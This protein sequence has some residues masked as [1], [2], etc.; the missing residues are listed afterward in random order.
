VCTSRTIHTVKLARSPA[1]VAAALRG[2]PVK[3]VAGELAVNP[4]TVLKAYRELDHRGVTAGRV[5]QGT[6]VQQAVRPLPAA[7]HASLQHG[8]QNWLRT[9]F[10]AGLA[11]EDIHALV[12]EAARAIRAEGG[13]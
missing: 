11:D 10:A 1:V 2:A 6:F 13:A 4:N 5:G 9:A 7:Q 12:A 8:L 3:D